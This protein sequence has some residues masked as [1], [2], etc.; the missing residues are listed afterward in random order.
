MLNL[1]IDRVAD[2]VPID[3]ARHSVLFPCR[4]QKSNSQKI[5]AGL[6]QS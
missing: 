3:F 6:P 1:E 5:A 4:F 2:A